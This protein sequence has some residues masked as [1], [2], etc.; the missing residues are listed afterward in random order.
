MGVHDLLL[1]DHVELPH[2][3]DL[4]VQQVI[5]WLDKLWGSF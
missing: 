1:H 2:V 3:L 4:A 5:F